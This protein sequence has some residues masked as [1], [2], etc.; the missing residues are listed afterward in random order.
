MVRLE[1]ERVEQPKTFQIETAHGLWPLQ[2]LSWHLAKSRANTPRI[3]SCPNRS[4][5]LDFHQEFQACCQTTRW[6]LAEDFW[7]G[8]RCWYEK[9]PDSKNSVWPEPQIRED[10]HLHLLDADIY[11]QR[12]ESGFEMQ[13]CLKDQVLWTLGCRTQFHCS[14]RKREENQR[15]FVSLQRPSDTNCRVEGNVL[16]R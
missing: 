6:R 14:Q 12:N 4:I 7:N 9:A 1:L 15:D 3:S 5:W 10:P 13:G 11:F 2:P 8:Q 16:C